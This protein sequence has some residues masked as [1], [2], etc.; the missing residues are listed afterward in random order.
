MAESAADL[1]RFGQRVAAVQGYDPDDASINWEAFGRRAQYDISKRRGVPT[2]DGYR[3]PGAEP[4]RA[5]AEA[6]ERDTEPA[7]RGRTVRLGAY[8]FSA[9]RLPPPVLHRP[10]HAQRRGERSSAGYYRRRWL[11]ERSRSRRRRGV[12]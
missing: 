6:E 10:R 1:A 3:Y 9:H 8:E 7:P 5:V 11:R 4:E 2:P 12:R